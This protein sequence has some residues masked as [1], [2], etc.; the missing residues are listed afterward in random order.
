MLYNGKMTRAKKNILGV[1]L[2]VLIAAFFFTPLFAFAIG[3]LP[4]GF[5]GLIL[6]VVPCADPPGAFLVD[7]FHPYP[8]INGL[9]IWTPPATRLWGP[10][11]AL[12]RILGLS[13]GYATCVITPDPKRYRAVEAKWISPLTG[14]GTSLIPTPF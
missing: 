5:G 1:A 14:A 3:P 2:A 7:V 6:S 4:S 13:F 12:R 8:W 11:L 10:P 9:Y